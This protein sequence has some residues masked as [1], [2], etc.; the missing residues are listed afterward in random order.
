MAKK[1]CVCVNCAPMRLPAVLHG[2]TCAPSR[3]QQAGRR[4]A[5]AK[6]K[7]N[8]KEVTGTLRN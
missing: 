5:A 6:S 7:R 3:A 8:G 1:A 2:C 4:W